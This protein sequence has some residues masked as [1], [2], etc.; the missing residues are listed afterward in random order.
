MLEISVIPDQVS[1]SVST[2]K[3]NVLAETINGTCR[4]I[5]GIEKIYN[6]SFLIMIL[7]SFYIILGFIGGKISCVALREIWKIDKLLII[8]NG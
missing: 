4:I 8:N 2:C 6:V 1:I 5:E 3:I 7:W